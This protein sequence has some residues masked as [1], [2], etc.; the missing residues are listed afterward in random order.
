MGSL[1]FMRDFLETRD[2]GKYF[3]LYEYVDRLPEYSWTY[4]ENLEDGHGYQE[5]FF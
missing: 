4:I 1:I 5:T 3:F 2:Y